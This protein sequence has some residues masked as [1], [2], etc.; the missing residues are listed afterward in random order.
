MV[1][2]SPRAVM[3][4]HGCPRKLSDNRF[5]SFPG[6]VRN[7]ECVIDDLLAGLGAGGLADG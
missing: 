6:A 3:A 1:M 4:L 5:F 7:T 2:L